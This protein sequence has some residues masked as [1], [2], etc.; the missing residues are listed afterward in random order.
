MEWLWQILALILGLGKQG[1]V[2]SETTVQGYAVEI[3]EVINPAKLELIPNYSEKVTVKNLVEQNNCQAAINGGFYDTTNKPLGL[4]VT[5]GNVTAE[6][7]LNRLFDG[8]VWTTDKKMGVSRGKPMENISFAVQTGPMLI[9]EQQVISL[10][11]TED[12]NARRMTAISDGERLWF[13]A[14]YDKESPV[15]GPLL[16]DLPEIIKD[17]GTQKE[18]T[19][20]EA[21]N[22]DGGLASAFYSPEVNLVEFAPVGSLWCIKK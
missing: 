3:V 10:K 12:K 6:E 5:K 4:V 18:W 13:A 20:T 22:L 8:V 19:I 14:I 16:T 21:V 9:D 17:I 1:A 11:L 7:K 2:I 15:N